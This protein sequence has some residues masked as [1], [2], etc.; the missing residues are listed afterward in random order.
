MNTDPTEPIRGA[1]E[2]VPP[3]DDVEQAVRPGCR[4]RRAAERPPAEPQ[5]DAVTAAGRSAAQAQLR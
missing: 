2:A 1:A 3:M 4:R 5:P